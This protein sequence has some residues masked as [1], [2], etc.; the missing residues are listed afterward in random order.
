MFYLILFIHAASPD[1][2]QE[3]WQEEYNAW[4]KSLRDWQGEF[5]AYKDGH[6]CS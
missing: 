1:E 4:K 3:E 5:E 2:L 6:S